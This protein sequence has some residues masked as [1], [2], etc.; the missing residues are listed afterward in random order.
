MSP[1]Q[2]SVDAHKEIVL[3]T[4]ADVFENAAHQ[5]AA[6]VDEFPEYGD[7]VRRFKRLQERVSTAARAV[8]HK[9]GR[10]FG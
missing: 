2:T 10:R 1:R 4:T 9:P 3:R 7:D 6:L 5:A 8:G